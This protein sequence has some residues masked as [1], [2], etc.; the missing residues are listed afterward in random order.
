MDAV[1]SHSR[2]AT[3]RWVGAE[4]VF[5]VAQAAVQRLLGLLRALLGSR[6]GL[7]INVLI[8]KKAL[9]LKLRHF[10]DPTFYDMLTRARREASSRPLSVVSESFLLVQNVLTLLGYVTLLLRFSGW[11]VLGLLLAALPATYA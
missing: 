8:L 5:I 4:L 1:V 10:E 7:D 9:T 6:L 2:E 3:L 11:A